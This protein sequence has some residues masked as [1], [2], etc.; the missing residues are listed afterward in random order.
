MNEL[1]IE[2]LKLLYHYDP[3]TGVFTRLNARNNTRP[4][5]LKTKPNTNG[6]LRLY[7]D[8]NRYKQHR[9]AIFYMTGEWPAKFVDHK[10]GDRARNAFSDLRDVSNQE[11][12]QN[13]RKAHRDSTTGILGVYERKNIRTGAFSKYTASI[14]SN[15]QQKTLGSFLTIEEAQEAYLSAKRQLHAGNTL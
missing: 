8:G 11:N 5:P 14:T 10:Y 7:I 9:L 13:Q 12:C 4:G 2:R 15:Y 3:E 1:T 6:Y